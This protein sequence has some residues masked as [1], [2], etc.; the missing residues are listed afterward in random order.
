MLST[1][2]GRSGAEMLETN[3]R[4]FLS[5]GETDVGVVGLEKEFRC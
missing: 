3:G 1:E 5:A 4:L 2:Y